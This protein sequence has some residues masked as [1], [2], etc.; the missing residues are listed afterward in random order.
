MVFLSNSVGVFSMSC[1]FKESPVN[2]STIEQ[3]RDID[4]GYFP[5]RDY[6]TMHFTF[7]LKNDPRGERR[8]YSWDQK[9]SDGIP[10]PI[11]YFQQEQFIFKRTKTTSSHVLISNTHTLNEMIPCPH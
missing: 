8:M 3:I 1:S 2:T 10:V 6:N 5:V 4:A 11:K 9:E 7:R